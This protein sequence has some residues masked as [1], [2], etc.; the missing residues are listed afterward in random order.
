MTGSRLERT[1]FLVAGGTGGHLFP[2]LATGAAL[3]RR[4]WQV[5]YGADERTWRYLGDVPED[6]RHLIRSASL[7]GRNPFR[8]AA[9]ATV[10][11]GG[12]VESLGLIRRVAP[13]V[14]VGFGGYPTLPPLVAA[15]LLGVPILVHEANIV[16]GRANRLLLRLGAELAISFPSVSGA[17]GRAGTYTGNPL[18]QAVLDAAAIPFEPPAGNEPFRL[19]MFGGSQGAKA[20]AELAPA[21]L[22]RLDVGARQRIRLTLQCRTE[23]LDEIRGRLQVLDVGFECAEFFAD[24]PDRIAASH[25][26]VSRA[27]ASTVFELAAIGRPAILV[28]YPHAL[29]HDQAANAHALA[30][31]GGAWIIEQSDLDPG[32]LARE[33]TD[34]MNSPER[35]R[36]AALASK[37]QGRPDAADRMAQLIETAAKEK[38]VEAAA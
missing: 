14:A 22:E 4:G 18:R 36:A 10:L 38:T 15:R 19:L 31:A 33:L 23:D 20:L 32:R 12:L 3:E 1:A 16:L 13:D 25:L 7:A 35:L 24:L 21:A 37:Q 29:D 27:G 2:A 8:L 28:P 9:A 26:V 30:E 11:G 5:R 34:L 17:E 6:R